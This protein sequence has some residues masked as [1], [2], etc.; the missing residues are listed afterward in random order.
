MKIVVCGRFDYIR[1]AWQPAIDNKTV[2]YFSDEDF[3]ALTFWNKC[4]RRWEQFCA[5]LSPSRKAE[6]EKLDN[7]RER[8]DIDQLKRSDEILF[9]LYETNFLTTDFETLEFLKNRFPKARFVLHMTN[10]IGTIRPRETEE[11][12]KHVDFFDL[13][14]TFNNLDAKEY[15]LG[16]FP[17][18]S[19]DYDLIE[20]ADIEPFD[21]FF[22]GR[23]K[24]RLDTILAFAKR[25]RA[26]GLSIR[27]LIVGAPE[28]K[29]E[30]IEGVTYGEYQPYLE[31]LATEK[32]AKAILNILG[33]VSSGIILRDEEAIGMNKLLITDNDYIF[34]SEYYNE[35]K[36]IPMDRFEEQLDKL[37]NSKTQ[38][39][40]SAKNT[41]REAFLSRVFND[42]KSKQEAK[43]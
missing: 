41:D 31:M 26:L 28:D 33:G 18:I 22:A 29:Q 30:A 27:F 9:V 7:L 40:S 2:F 32:R 21:V 10:A 37:Q 15:G 1:F 13:V 39:P 6:L 3:R 36:I 23:A 24:E 11:L 14:Y 20:P 17:D 38:W 16:F 5:R 4:R 25:C 42:L 12:V 34:T 19:G 35:S 43:Q 8:I